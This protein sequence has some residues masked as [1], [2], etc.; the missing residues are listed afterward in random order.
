M[1]WIGLIMQML[2]I[3]LSDKVDADALIGLIGHSGERRGRSWRI[4]PAQPDVIR[5]AFLQVEDLPVGRGTVTTIELKLSDQ[6][7]T[8][9]TSIN[10]ALGSTARELPSLPAR[11]MPGGSSPRPRIF[12]WDVERDGRRGVVMITALPAAGDSDDIAVIEILVRRH[13]N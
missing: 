9:F 6:W 12:A 7:K 10:S 4:D 2:T 3:L 8:N 1:D 13:Y 11:I 5:Q